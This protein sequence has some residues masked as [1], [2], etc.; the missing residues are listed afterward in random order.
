MQ[1]ARPGRRMAC[2]VFLRQAPDS[3]ATTAGVER[4]VVEPLGLVAEEF[5]EEPLGPAAEDEDAPRGGALARRQVGPR[6]GLARVRPRGRHQAVRVEAVLVV[7]PADGEV[8]IAR[9]GGTATEVLARRE[10][11][12]TASSYASGRSRPRPAARQEK[13]PRQA[14]HRERQDDATAACLPQGA[15]GRRPRPPPHAPPAGQR[16]GADAADEDEREEDAADQAAGGLPQVHA[17]DRPGLVG[18]R[19]LRRATGRSA[20]GKVMPTRTLTGSVAR[21]VIQSMRPGR[22]TRRG[23][24]PARAAPGAG[25]RSRPQ[26]GG[27]DRAAT[28]NVS[29]GRSERSRNRPAA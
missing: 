2:A 16:D 13:D 14:G 19:C 15:A 5:L 24:R 10:S 8:L 6:G 21:A 7:E 18:G 23:R 29:H 28:A 22:R 12:P 26:D 27:E 20:A 17:A 3:I 9:V 25:A 4:D 1:V 11:S